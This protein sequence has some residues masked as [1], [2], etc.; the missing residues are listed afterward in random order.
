MFL[1][2]FLIACVCNCVCMFVLLLCALLSVY[3]SVRLGLSLLSVSMS[4]YMHMNVC[5]HCEYCP[6]LSSFWSR[7]ASR[8]LVCLCINSLCTCRVRFV[9]RSWGACNSHT[10]VWTV[11]CSKASLHTKRPSFTNFFQP[12]L[13]LCVIFLSICFHFFSMSNLYLMI[14]IGPHCSV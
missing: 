11:H 14:L 9:W 5:M 1:A 7:F 2:L 12:L 6:H 13:V 10:F 3:V 4:S 8:C